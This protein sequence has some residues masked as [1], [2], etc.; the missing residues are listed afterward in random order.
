M[1]SSGREA[2]SIAGR[3]AQPCV[4]GAPWHVPWG[5]I[6][7]HAGIGESRDRDVH[8][9]DS[10]DQLDPVRADRLAL[11]QAE[12]PTV[13]VANAQVARLLHEDVQA[14]EVD[15]EV[16]RGREVDDADEQVGQPSGLAHSRG[17]ASGRAWI[18]MPPRR[19]AGPA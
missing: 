14:Q 16:A 7:E 5:S 6:D 10:N 1:L 18:V 8:V 4:P 19:T 11:L 15:V 9:R 2:D 3:I 13:C 12:M 17:T